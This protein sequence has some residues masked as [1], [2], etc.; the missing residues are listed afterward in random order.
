M[1]CEDGSIERLLQFTSPVGLRPS[2]G[3]LMPGNRGLAQFVLA[4]VGLDGSY[5]AVRL[6]Q[7]FSMKPDTLGNRSRYLQFIRG[8][9]KAL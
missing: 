3:E 6:D 7:E 1:A 5:D 9:L 4:R 8:S 2:L